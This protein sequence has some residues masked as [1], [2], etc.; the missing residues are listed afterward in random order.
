MK[1]AILFYGGMALGVLSSAAGVYLATSIH[2]HER[3]YTVFAA[4]IACILAGFI[5]K[6]ARPG[7][8]R[9]GWLSVAM[10]F[11][12]LVLGMLTSAAGASLAVIAHYH[13]RAYAFLMVGMICLLVG[14]ARVVVAPAILKAARLSLKR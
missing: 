8:Q 3:A 11:D 5:A 6:H 13:A 7:R 1:Q 12:V 2:Y 4:G 10:C 9:S 14:L